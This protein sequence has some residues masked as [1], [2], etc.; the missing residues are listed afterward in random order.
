MLNLVRKRVLAVGATD[1]TDA[2]SGECRPNDLE[3]PLARNRLRLPRPEFA[4]S[5]HACSIIAGS[6]SG[7]LHVG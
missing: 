3:R 1:R 6:I 2:H 5:D 4:C 7:M